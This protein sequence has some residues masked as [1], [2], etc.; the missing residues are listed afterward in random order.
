MQVIVLLNAGA[1][2]AHEN[3]VD[4][5]EFTVRGAFAAAG[6]CAEVRHIQ[7]TWLTA[8]AQRIAGEGQAGTII[9]A[10]GGDGTQS[11]VAAALAGT[12]AGIGGLSLGTTQH[13]STGL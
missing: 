12:S 4:G 3:S 9:V 5:D 1:G 11:A 10:A 2:I 7:G 8:A 6:L 13:L